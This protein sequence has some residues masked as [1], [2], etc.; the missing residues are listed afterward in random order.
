MIRRV[1]LIAFIIVLLQIV[2]CKKCPPNVFNIEN[3]V[4]SW[5]WADT[6]SHWVYL[7]NKFNDD[8]ISTIGIKHYFEDDIKSTKREIYELVSSNN[9]MY[10]IVGQSLIFDVSDFSKP[11]GGS[12]NPF[13]LDYASLIGKKPEV[14]LMTT[15]S[16]L[17]KALP[18]YNIGNN[19]FD[20]TLVWKVYNDF[21]LE[22]DSSTYYFSKGVGFTRIVDY[23][24][25]RDME[26]VRYKIKRRPDI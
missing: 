11:D 13:R 2:S 9:Y 24:H 23:T 1:F 12:F 4:K 15:T 7:V 20:S 3:Y 17:I 22:S 6:G 25:N 16:H 14:P 26:L 8:S 5:F 10:S 19:T 21:L 18:S